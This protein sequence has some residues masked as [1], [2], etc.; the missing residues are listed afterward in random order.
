MIKII[1]PHVRL[2]LFFALPLLLTS[3][4]GSEETGS[5]DDRLL[6]TLQAVAPDGDVG[7]FI[8]PQSNEY[9]LLPQDP[10]NPITEAKVALGKLLFH[11]TGM[12]IHPKNEKGRETYSCASCHHASGGFQACLPQGVGEG[13]W[14]F[15][16]TGESRTNDASYLEGELDVQPI[17]TPSA[18]NSAY[19]EVT[20]WNGQFGATG[21]NA[22]TEAQWTDG[23]PIEIN[24]L[25]Y[26]GVETQAIAGLD[27]HR[28]G[29]SEELLDKGYRAYFDAAF[30]DVPE[31][32]RYSKEYAGLA[33]AAYERTLTATKAPFQEW[34]KGRHSVMSD[35][36]KEGAILFFGSAKC[37]S[38]HTGPALNSME[39]HALGM[40]DLQGPNIFGDPSLITN[41]GRG[42]FTRKPADNYK[43]KV[44]QLYSLAASPFYG[45]GGN[46][47]SIEEVVEYKNQ[48]L[49]ANIDVPA[50]QL[51]D[52]FVPLG[53]SSS[54]VEAI[55]AFIQY[56]LNDK[57]LSR[58][59]PEELPTQNCFPNNDAQSKEDRGCD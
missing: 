59:E 55:T 43:F 19:Q 46:F 23:T 7:Y 6:N 38:C 1:H 32:E 39:F 16:L 36:E 18:L 20:L 31:A 3:C 2:A 42:G 22:G 34:L 10:K 15:G 5:L 21:L 57:E 51:S 11:E 30:P 17:R 45:H 41:L 25:G 8:L 29:I 49:A 56:S 50:Q 35:Q 14:G 47:T 12:A 37:V 9:H 44:P 48:A 52:E 54:E 33:I 53:L 58:Y 24:K 40:P 4:S 27:V 13:G 26:Q 28:L